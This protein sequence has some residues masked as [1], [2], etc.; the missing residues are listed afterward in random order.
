MQE[1]VC[2]AQKTTKLTGTRTAEIWAL[3]GVEV[4]SQ[5][6]KRRGVKLEGLGS[7]LLTA[8]G[9]VLAQTSQHWAFARPASALGLAAVVKRAEDLGKISRKAVAAVV[10]AMCG[11]FERIREKKGT[12]DLSL[13]PVGVLKTSRGKTRLDVDPDFRAIV[14]GAWNANL[15]QTAPQFGGIQ[16]GFRTDQRPASSRGPAAVAT[17]TAKRTGKRLQANLASVP[18]SQKLRAKLIDMH[19]PDALCLFGRA[20]AAAAASTSKLPKLLSAAF[21]DVGL[22]DQADLSAFLA[23]CGNDEI[24]RRMAAANAT[25]AARVQ[26]ID[27]IWRAKCVDVARREAAYT[28]G[29]PAEGAVFVTNELPLA[30]LTKCLDMTWHN[31]D[32]RDVRH[33]FI[34]HFDAAPNEDGVLVVSR[35][36]W[37]ATMARVSGAYDDDQDFIDAASTAWGHPQSNRKKTNDNDPRPPLQ[38]AWDDVPGVD[39]VVIEDDDDD[40][41]V[42]PPQEE[43]SVEEDDTADDEKN[44]LGAAHPSMYAMV[45]WRDVVYSPPCDLNEV[46][47]RLAVTQLQAS[48]TLS[49]LECRLLARGATV[50]RLTGTAAL[51]PERAR[52]LVQ[53]VATGTQVSLALLHR[54]L[55]RLFGK[56]PA[57]RSG[58]LQSVISWLPKIARLVSALKARRRDEPRDV[59][60]VQDLLDRAGLAVSRQKATAIFR[61]VV[62]A[63]SDDTVTFATPR[64]ADRRVTLD[65]VLAALRGCVSSFEIRRDIVARVYKRLCRRFDHVPPTALALAGQLKRPTSDAADI[66]TEFRRHFPRDTETVDKAA[67]DEFYQNLS[68][69]I[70]GDYNLY[71]HLR[72]AWGL[73]DAEARAE[74]EALLLSP[75]DT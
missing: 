4:A 51:S 45:A 19:G 71:V 10:S 34:S 46:L 75:T 38:R 26:F 12:A 24:E 7:I 50:A 43:P 37:R 20:L 13:R 48:P 29:A 59:A 62:Q 68:P 66:I 44:N 74:L 28:R 64:E 2:V 52:Y 72:E 11:A 6:K 40:D 73:N 15:K 1:L 42:I 70:N 55:A 21:S 14:A 56:S 53:S 35:S 16:A 36:N 58:P 3:V 30:V 49:E 27:D 5:L 9:V 41:L 17:T 61:A 54:R 22:Y 60:G 69:M 57:E 65:E 32:N 23:E 67:F 39:D 33:R 18:A 63:S 31:N 47:V 8:E 25:S